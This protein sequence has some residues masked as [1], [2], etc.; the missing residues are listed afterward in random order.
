MIKLICFPDKN[1]LIF[2]LEWEGYSYMHPGEKH[3]WEVSKGGLR[4][5]LRISLNWLWSFCAW[6]QLIQQE[7]GITSFLKAAWT[8][9]L[10]KTGSWLFFFI[11]PMLK[12]RCTNFYWL[13][14]AKLYV[15]RRI[16]HDFYFF[17][18]SS[19]LMYYSFIILII[20]FYSPYLFFIIILVFIY[21][22]F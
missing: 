7:L 9:L 21:L 4:F 10:P 6:E 3:R 18:L 8:R 20:I 22:F 15:T 1:K 12:D 19:K 14:F 5:T 11:S 13:S 16:T 2:Q 17:Q